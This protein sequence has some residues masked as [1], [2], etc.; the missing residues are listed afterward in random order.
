MSARPHDWV[1]EMRS[2]AV[3]RADGGGPWLVQGVDWMVRAGE[4]WVLAGPMNAGKSALLETVAGL[5]PM[6]DGTLRVMGLNWE[7]LKGDALVSLRMRVGVV[8]D[9]GG[10]LFPGL[11]VLENVALPLCYHRNWDMAE[12]AEAVG[13]WLETAGLA[14]WA[15]ETAGT[16]SPPWARRAAL[17]RALVL[18]PELL[19]L[20]EP[21]AGLDPAHAG[22][23]ED[24]LGDLRSG[25]GLVD[26]H[27]MTLVLTAS[28]PSG[29]PHWGDGVRCAVTEQ[30]RWRDIGGLH[31]L[32]HMPGPWRE[33]GPAGR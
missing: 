10:R 15:L 24:F 13:G 16:L 7:D 4:T 21:L 27:G 23:W 17:L 2:G 20:D 33:A 3:G 30:G 31:D 18:R 28:T 14:R 26:G 5:R 6:G 1:V 9:G 8:F 32:A 25:C 22:W 11:T 29:L 19:L 12:A